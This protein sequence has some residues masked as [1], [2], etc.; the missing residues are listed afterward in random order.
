M[1]ATAVRWIFL[2]ACLQLVH[3]VTAFLR[4]A[5]LSRQGGGLEVRSRSRTPVEGSRSCM[6]MAIVNQGKLLVLGGTGTLGRVVVRQAID[7]GYD[8]KCML[9]MPRMGDFL[10]DWGAEIVYGDLE[11]PFSIC[12]P[13]EDV[14]AVIDCACTRPEELDKQVKIDWEGKFAFLQACAEAGID[15]YVMFSFPDAEKFAQASSVVRL[16]AAL[17]EALKDSDIPYTIFRTP[18]F[19]NGVYNEIMLPMMNFETVWAPPRDAKEKGV[20]YIY[21]EDAARMALRALEVPAA[22]RKILDLVGPEPISTKYVF[23]VCDEVLGEVSKN[24]KVNTVSPTTLKAAET[25]A[26]L[27]RWGGAFARQ[28]EFSGTK[29]IDK[30][31]KEACELLGIKESSLE[32]CSSYLEK[33]A[34]RQG[35]QKK[36]LTV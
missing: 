11:K 28:V 23:D 27:F 12:T 2:A 5:L 8:V 7:R 20:P 18:G 10:K 9:R 30:S 16:K 6:R 34:G 14:T 19:Y 25:A 35:L 24:A 36:T 29:E 21:E 3:P 13:L 26:R 31:P 1:L 17:E 4:G 15:Q 33:L 32:T 22:K